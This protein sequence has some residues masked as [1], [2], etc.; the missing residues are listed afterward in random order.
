M[1]ELRELR[2][3][4]LAGTIDRRDF[5]LGAS[6]LGLGAA[7]ASALPAKARAATRGGHLR[8]GVAQGSTT[9]SSEPGTFE[10]GFTILLS[11]T[12]QGKL[13]V[14]G[15][16]NQLHGDLAE[17]WEGTDQA[18]K[19]VFELRDA[20]FHGGRPVTA[21]DVVASLNHHRG[22][23]TR[24]AAKPILE[25]VT[26]IRADGDKTVIV[27]LGGG[28]ADFPFIMTDY[29]L[30]IG[31]ADGEGKVDWNNPDGHSGPYRMAEFEPGVR[32]DFV[33]ADN[34]WNPEAGYVDT[35]EVLA[36]LD[37]VARQT[38]LLGD[39]IDVCERP[40]TRT[41]DRLAQ[42]PGIVVEESVG[43][44]F[45]AFNMLMDTPPF[46]NPDVR[47]ALKYGLDRGELLAKALNGRGVL[48][49]DHP[50]TP[51]YR[52]F[53]DGIPQ[54]EQD[55][56][57]A[58]YH[59]RQAG[60]ETLEIDLSASAAAFASAVDA[61]LL[62]KEH[63]APIGININVTQEPADGY[64]SNVWMKKPFIA[65]DWGGRPTEDQMFSVA[66]QSGVPWNDT[67]FSDERF[68][69]LLIA[70]RSELDQNLR[71]EMYGEMQ[72]ILHDRGGLIVPM[73]PNSI[74]ARHERVGRP[75]DIS[76]AWQMDGL[77]LVSRWWVEG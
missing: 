7:A 50:I 14:I 2:S 4:Y 45:H 57:K 61:A 52:F 12:S 15:Q 9:D 25:A 51:S 17:S 71:A 33:R 34:Y 60:F 6:A 16:D 31:A 29:Q 21:K 35:A 70:A 24:S 76:T 59:L 38:A 36:I 11:Y 63:V 65:S 30:S 39:E 13:T 58:R 77:Q 26:D 47:L 3:K 67:N 19:W 10:N 54:R 1:S 62:F 56:D 53:D 28:N 68:D 64:W 49:N 42:A 23:D 5:L 27:E 43:F 40:E 37:P 72:R 55:L 48:G 74:W 44:R 69:E 8:V 66:F 46:D 18:R 41:I 32:A 20:E 22:D 73:L 75:E